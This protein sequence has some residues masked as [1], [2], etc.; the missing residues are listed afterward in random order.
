MKTIP[1]FSQLG[2]SETLLNAV[3]K[4]GFEEPT[5]IQALTIPVML[6]GDN[7]IIAQAQTGTG[8]TAAFGLPLLDRAD[9]SRS[10]VQA[11]VLAPTRELAVQVSEEMNSL[12]PDGSLRIVPIYGGQAIGQQLNR[13]KRGVH[14]VVGTPGRVIDHLHRKTLDLSH[15]DYLVL[16]EADEMLNMGFLEDMEEIMAHTPQD[17]RTLLF[18]AT[19]PPRIKSLAEKYMEGYQ[20][21]KVDQSPLTTD[22]TEQRY[23]EV[24]E[25]DKFEALCRMVDM[26]DEF[27]G[28]VFCRTKADVDRVASHLSDR[29]YDAG[30]I[31][32]DISQA[33]R[34][35]TLD[36]FK[37][38]TITLLVATDVAARGIDVQDLTHVINFSLPQDP[39]S[40][41]HRIGRT[42]RAGK[43]GT[44]VTFITPREY[45]RL[46][47]IQRMA[48][49]D[50]KKSR[51]P[52]VNEILKAKR[53]KVYK[54]IA[55]LK[56]KGIEE[57][58]QG[59]ALRL[60]EEQDPLETLAA[61]L[62]ITYGEEMNPDSYREIQDLS[63]PSSRE[64]SGDRGGYSG[65]SSR[66][67][68]RGSSSRKGGSGG[69]G[70]K[71]SNAGYSGKGGYQGRKSSSGKGSF[72]G[73]GKPAGKKGKKGKKGF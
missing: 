66:G 33:Q 54:D 31:H 68:E 42:G 17:K 55:D 7:N 20:H 45:K 32:G 73:K 72:P 14:V 2:L 8:K 19:M 43:S 36:Q 52:R 49:S 3:R 34:E 63:R 70:R 12:K 22:L 28:L 50:I 21:L 71:S 41:V 58:Y 39:E 56:E 51:V 46:R 24:R 29:G 60:L 5:A 62:Q 18:S 37:K 30:C 13:L 64:R 40:Y 61:L 9:S 4:K 47:F 27:Y 59:W 11:L 26:E 6:Q 69:K 15:L 57:A 65:R 10:Q 1:P 53:R 35:R 38:R 48:G 23:F 16:D 67:G 25:S 44:A